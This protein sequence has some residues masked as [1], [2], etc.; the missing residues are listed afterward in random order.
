MSSATRIANSNRGGG[1]QHLELASSSGAGWEQLK[2]RQEQ[3][4]EWDS[5][6]RSLQQ[7]IVELLINNRE[8]RTPLPLKTNHR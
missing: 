3:E 8:I 2:W 6:L 4:R 5:N 7:C 1:F